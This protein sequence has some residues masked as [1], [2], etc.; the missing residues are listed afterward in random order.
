[1]EQAFIIG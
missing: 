1:M